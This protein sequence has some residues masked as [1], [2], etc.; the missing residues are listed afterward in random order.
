MPVD[1]TAAACE[2]RLIITYLS[3]WDKFWSP[4]RGHGWRVIRSLVTQL[5]RLS[6]HKETAALLRPAQP[7]KLRS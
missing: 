7:N 5:R 2:Y 1:T 6:V 4:F 3:P